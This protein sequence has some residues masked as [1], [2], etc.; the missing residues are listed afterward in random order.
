G[1][2][3]HPEML[4]GFRSKAP[5][6]LTNS[7]S[8]WSYYPMLFALSALRT[9]SLELALPLSGGRSGSFLGFLA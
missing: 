1:V 5:K 8:A 6:T 4:A 7:G 3:G 2:W 9:L